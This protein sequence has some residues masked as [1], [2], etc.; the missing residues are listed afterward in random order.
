M[1]TVVIASSSCN[2]DAPDVPP[3]FAPLSFARL[4]TN[5]SQ[6]CFP[7]SSLHAPSGESN[8]QNFQ[9]ASNIFT[10]GK[11]I[12]SVKKSLRIIFAASNSSIPLHYAALLL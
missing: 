5:L 11:T 9:Q 10:A 2:S 8:Q 6:L 4:A 7:K 3:P 1:H 12:F